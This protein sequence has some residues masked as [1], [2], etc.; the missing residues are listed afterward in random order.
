MKGGTAGG[1]G[2]RRFGEVPIR[3]TLAHVFYLVLVC[4]SFLFC[5]G[6]GE[7]RETMVFVL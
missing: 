7:K 1:G 4:F 5:F 6:G 2:G 3:N